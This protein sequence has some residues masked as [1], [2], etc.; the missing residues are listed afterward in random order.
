MGRKKGDEGKRRRRAAGLLNVLEERRPADAAG[1]CF[2]GDMGCPNNN[3][4]VGYLAKSR[5]I[6]TSRETRKVRGERERI[7]NRGHCNR[8]SR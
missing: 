2:A 1:R 3:L 8:R 4:K 5:I 7:H 6:S